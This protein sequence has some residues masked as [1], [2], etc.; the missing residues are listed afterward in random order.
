MDARLPYLLALPVLLFGGL[1]LLRSGHVVLGAAALILLAVVIVLARR[2]QK[3]DMARDAAAHV[4]DA[5]TSAPV[6]RG[7]ARGE[8]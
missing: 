5:D 8:G 1:A 3:A 4:D 6:D 7:G 2:T